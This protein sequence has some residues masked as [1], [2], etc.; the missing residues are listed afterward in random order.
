MK[1][2]E[3]AFMRM[4][5][6]IYLA[7]HLRRAISRKLELYVGAALNYP[8]EYSRVDA[9]VAGADADA[10]DAADLAD[11]VEVHCSKRK[12][13]RDM[14]ESLMEVRSLLYGGSQVASALLPVSVAFT[15]A[16]RPLKQT[17]GPSK[18]RN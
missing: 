18:S 3:N 10:V 4:I 5:T 8:L 11:V 16:T 9:I 15:P 7:G 6:K 14:R 17:V 12:E 13:G 2:I 1:V